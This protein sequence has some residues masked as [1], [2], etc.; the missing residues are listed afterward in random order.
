MNREETEIIIL[1][2][3]QGLQKQLSDF[4]AAEPTYFTLHQKEDRENFEKV[5]QALEGIKKHLET[6]DERS[7]I[8]YK[9]QR[10]FMLRMTPVEDGLR[11]AQGL[12]KF[13]KW[14]GLPGLVVFVY[15]FFSK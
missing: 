7:E 3:T 14:I 9:E 15:W 13:F 1:K 6:Q 4:M 2:A 10:E 8:R 5:F 12:N 11:V